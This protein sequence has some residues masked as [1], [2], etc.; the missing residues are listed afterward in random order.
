[1]PEAPAATADLSTTSTSSPRSARCQAVESPWTP[2]PTIRCRVERMSVER[3]LPALEHGR[4]PVRAD[5]AGALHPRPQLR[6]REL[7]VL[8]LQPDP[9]GVAGLQVGDQHLAGDLVL[10]PFGDVEVD[11]QERVGVA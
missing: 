3:R 10:T 6:L 9:V 1:M 11:L 4:L 8:L 5:R 7:A 2:A